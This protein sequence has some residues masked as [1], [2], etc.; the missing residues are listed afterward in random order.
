MRGPHNQRMSSA[1]N[2]PLC[3]IRERKHD[4]NL[5]S[6]F[7]APHRLCGTRSCGKRARKEQF[8]GHER[9]LPDGRHP[10]PA[11]AGDRARAS[12]YVWGRSF[13]RWCTPGCLRNCRHALAAR[14]RER[15]L[16]LRNERTQ[17]AEK[18]TPRIRCCRGACFRFRV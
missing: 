10:E 9:T 12:G 2:A 11:A 5:L 17:H 15:A 13:R 18:K 6:Y 3:N 16:A 1:V 7:P 14:K 4:C 8:H